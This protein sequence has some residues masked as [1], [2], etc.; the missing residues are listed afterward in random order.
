MI[1]AQIVYP[2]W[3]V[4]HGISKVHGSFLLVIL[5]L[6]TF[7]T[8]SLR[9]HKV[10]IWLLCVNHQPPRSP[11]N[12][13]ASLSTINRYLEAIL[14][15]APL[16]S[17]DFHDTSPISLRN[18]IQIDIWV[19]WSNVESTNLGD[20]R[21]KPWPPRFW[22][23]DLNHPT[24]CNCIGLKAHQTN[25]METFRGSLTWLNRGKAE[26]WH[27]WTKKSAPFYLAMLSGPRPHWNHGF[28]RELIP[29]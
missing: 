15:Q 13:G 19:Y 5:W 6:I 8:C 7:C 1:V 4:Y 14:L 16:P 3:W 29:T 10:Q 11:R 20:I 21:R 28:Y 9:V 18:R 24:D 22:K 23:V 2:G 26:H 12:F 17:L 27:C 25:D